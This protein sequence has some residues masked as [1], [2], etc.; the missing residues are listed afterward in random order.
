MQVKKAIQSAKAIVKREGVM[1]IALVLAVLTSFFNMPRVE[2]IDFKVL[3]VL[4]SLMLVIAGFKQNKLLDYIAL[5]ILR[6]TGSSRSLY[7][8]FIFM[9]FFA[10]MLITNDVALLTFVPLTLIIG[11][12][13]HRDMAKMVIWETIAA[14]LGSAFTPMGNPQNL[15]L[16]ARY[17][18]TAGEFFATTLP[19]VVFSALMLGVLAAREGKAAIALELSTT[20]FGNKVNSYLFVL[21][22]GVNILAVFQVLNYYLAFLLTAGVVAAVSPRLF[23]QVDYTLLLTFVGF[24]VFIG[25]ISTFSFVKP[26]KQYMLNSPEGVYLSG[27]LVSQFVSNVPAA[28]LLAG[29]TERGRELVLGVN[30][31]GLGTLI[32]SMASVISYKLYAENSLGQSGNYLRQFL[33]YNFFF[34]IILAP[35]VW[36]VRI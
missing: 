29:F 24:F 10:S 31:G 14:N 21:L 15:F 23:K 16:Y 35:L 8:L 27:I 6:K 19:L 30:V 22:L 9:T 2:Y 17:N 32:A 36:L 13:I 26:L 33:F 20:A 5:R 18:F 25:N 1:V 34:L 11:K 7:L 12:N 4:F 28:M 3:T